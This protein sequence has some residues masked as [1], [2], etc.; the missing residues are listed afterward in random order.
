MGVRARVRGERGEGS[1]SEKGEGTGGGR[2]ESIEGEGDMQFLFKHTSVL[3]NFAA[4]FS[5]V[6]WVAGLS[7]A[8]RRG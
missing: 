7:Q 5:R 3:F 8:P 1:E 2:W 6:R 4:A